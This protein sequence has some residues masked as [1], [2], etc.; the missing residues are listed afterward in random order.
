MADTNQS[1][2][3]THFVVHHDDITYDNT[4]TCV[5]VHPVVEVFPYKEVFGFPTVWDARLEVDA[6]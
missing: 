6:V 3:N 4:L 5:H 2:K 1:I